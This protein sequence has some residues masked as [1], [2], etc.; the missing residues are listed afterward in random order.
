MKFLSKLRKFAKIR[1]LIGLF[2]IGVLFLVLGTLALRAP[3][4]E[5][6]TADHH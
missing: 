6:L 4:T 5:K 2:L 3:K 1:T